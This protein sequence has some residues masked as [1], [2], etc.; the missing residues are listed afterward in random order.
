MYSI[1]DTTGSTRIVNPRRLLKLQIVGWMLVALGSGIALINVPTFYQYV[2]DSVRESEALNALGVSPHLIATLRLAVRVFGELCFFATSIAVLLRSRDWMAHLLAMTW[3]LYA[4]V[5]SGAVIEV[6]TAYPQLALPVG[7][8]TLISIIL[9]ALLLF[10]LPNGQFVPRWSK[11]LLPVLIVLDGFRLAFYGRLPIPNPILFIPVLLIYGMGIA[12]QFYRYRQ[13]K[14]VYRHQFKWMLLGSSIYLASVIIGQ[15]CYVF[16]PRDFHVLTAGLDE[17]GAVGLATCMIFALSRYR[18]YDINLY[19]NRTL[20]SWVVV[21]ALGLIF[22]PVFALSEA[23]V[24]RI[25]GEQERGWAILLPAVIVGACFNPVRSQ[26]QHFIDRRV[27]RLRFDLNELSRGQVTPE[28]QRRGI[29]TGQTLGG[30]QLYDVIGIGAMGEVYRGYKGDEVAA[31]KILLNDKQHDE[32]FFKRFEREAR[33]IAALDHPNIVKTYGFGEHNGAYYLAL[34]Y[35][36]GI[37]LDE[38]L[39]SRGQLSLSD[40]VPLIQELAEALDFAHAHGIIHRDIKPSNIRLRQHDDNETYQ[41]V[42]MD[43]GIAKMA[44]DSST[45]TGADAVGTIAYMSPEQFRESSTVD[46]RTDIYALGAVTYELLTGEPPFSGSPPQVMFAHLQQPAPDARDRVPDI[47][48]D[49]AMALRRALAKDPQLR[50]D[51]AG[52]FAE[53]LVASEHS[54]IVDTQPI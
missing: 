52:R 34:E 29:Y 27:Y 4:V 22:V 28:V 42:L 14:P 45:L 26:V 30:F 19:V 54:P 35:V 46:Y 10:T 40:A 11:W 50:F 33:V 49:V 53:V 17:W 21:L 43:F 7:I 5:L 1:N 20:V 37:G 31:V 47:P 9:G 41:V 3:A 8:L 24:T 32:V 36:E 15:L 39:R 51:S 25:L 12:A 2:V 38:L 6:V 23:L 16:I 18:L 44:D 48:H 13:G